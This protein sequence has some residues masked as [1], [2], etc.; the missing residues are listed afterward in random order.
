MKKGTILK[1]SEEGL[2]WLSGGDAGERAKLTFKRF[3]FRCKA[4]EAPECLS[5]KLVGK[6]YYRTYHQSFLEEDKRVLVLRITG[7]A[8][9]VFEALELLTKSRGNETLGQIVE[10]G[11]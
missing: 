7:K 9:D 3:E 1:F 8:K 5:V 10:Q 6:N 11:S 4:R 2:D